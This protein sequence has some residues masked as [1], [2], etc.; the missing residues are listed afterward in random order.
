MTA[1]SS[2]GKGWYDDLIGL[3]PAVIVPHVMGRLH[4]RRREACCSPRS[5]AA[6]GALLVAVAQR[7]WAAGP[8]FIAAARSARPQGDLGRHTSLV[9]DHRS[10]S[11]L[12]LRSGQCS[13]APRSR[14]SSASLGLATVLGEACLQFWTNPLG[15]LTIP[16]VAALVGYGT[17]WVGVKMIF[18]PINYWGLAIRRWPEQPLGMI[19]WQGIVPCKVRKMS[20]RL[21]DIITVKLLS[22]PEA[23]AR[24]DPDRL[25][26]LLEP[27][28]ARAIERE[29]WLGTLWIALFRPKL[30][31]LL[32]EVVQQMQ[33]NIEE[34]LNLRA[35]VSQAFLRDKVLLGELFQKAGRRELKFL[36]DSGLSFGFILGIFQMALWICVPSSWTLPLG[37]A[38]VG[39]ITNWVAI[40]LIFDPVEPTPVGPFVFQGLFEKRQPEVSLEFSEFLAERVLSSPQ[41]IS[42]IAKGKLRGNF[43]SLVQKN[44]PEYVPQD[45]VSAAIGAF[46]RLAKAP[47]SHPLHQYVNQALGLEETLNVRLRALSSQEF[48]NLLHPVFQEDEVILIVAGGVLGAAAGFLQMAF[49]WGG[50]PAAAAGAVAAAGATATEAAAMMLPAPFVLSRLWWAA[51]GGMAAVVATRSAARRMLRGLLLRVRLRLRR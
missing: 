2:P 16:V 46:R 27:E 13:R 28:V 38:L 37:G 4:A 11:W 23:F 8:C 42:E 41:L 30:L 19:G 7:P 32:T 49:G 21:V 26:E 44:I 6:A 48:E 15:Y 29:A 1:G 33:E 25:A 51:A 24:L 47:D 5:T 34:L 17:N 9:R 3:Q 31:P 50:P 12:G 39:Y 45:V 22:M 20:E 10:P 35:V 14:T 40:K 36:V 18:Y 43:E